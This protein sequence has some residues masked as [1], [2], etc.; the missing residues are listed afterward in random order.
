MY[1]I[2]SYY[3]EYRDRIIFEKLEA[4]VGDFGMAPM[5]ESV[6]LGEILAFQIPRVGNWGSG[7]QVEWM[8]DGQSIKSEEASDPKINRLRFKSDFLDTGYHE[9][10][11]RAIE[12]DSGKIVAHLSKRFR[13]K[14]P[15]KAD[16]KEFQA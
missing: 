9:L 2:R 15:T 4:F 1:A 6:A 7:W 12:T 5:E 8:I 11:V 3:V 14:D 10:A 13:V 16:L